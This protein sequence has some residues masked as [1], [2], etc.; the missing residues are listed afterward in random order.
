MIDM[1][2]DPEADAV[3]IYLGRGKVA[4]TRDEGPFIYDVDASGRILGIEIL[5]ASKL[6]APG[7]WKKSRLPGDPSVDAAE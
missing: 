3:Y 7:D 6:L 4:E 2:Y 1:T 5:A